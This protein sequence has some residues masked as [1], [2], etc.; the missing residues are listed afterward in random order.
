MSVWTPRGPRPRP[1]LVGE[2][3]PGPA[4]SQNP[5]TD[6]FRRPIQTP[7]P[8]PEVSPPPNWTA[9]PSNVPDLT[10]PGFANPQPGPLSPQNFPSY[11]AYAAAQN[12]A[13]P[14]VANPQA[15]PVSNELLRFGTVGGQDPAARMGAGL[16]AAPVSP[17]APAGRMP[18]PPNQTAPMNPRLPQPRMPLPGPP[19]QIPT[20][21]VSPRAPGGRMPVDLGGPGQ[22]VSPE[23]GR[24]IGSGGRRFPG[25]P[26]SPLPPG[27]TSAI[28]MG[29]GW[30][31]PPEEVAA[32]QADI[33]QRAATMPP[34]IQALLS[35]LFGAR[36]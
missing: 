24:L 19:P 11:E 25:E 15:D 23:G 1:S 12:P 10:A 34:Q 32:R 4:T 5:W 7:P 33:S 20:A 22:P 28:P 13:A 31:A 3:L 8:S 6:I 18:M 26:G 21:P 2:N 30:N 27:M 35:R 16:A 14:N 9:P 17:Q 29:T 36:G